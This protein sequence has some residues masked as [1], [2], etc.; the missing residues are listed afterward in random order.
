MYLDLCL[1]DPEFRL[2]DSGRVKKQ[3]NVVSSQQV[4]HDLSTAVGPNMC[5]TAVQGAAAEAV[6]DGA[7][8]EDGVGIGRAPTLVPVS[9]RTS[10][11][12]RAQEG[13]N[14]ENGKEV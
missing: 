3:R 5:T 11:L 13:R 6:W 7:A 9:L 2:S 14:A 4:R 8:R 12:R 1:T 10:E